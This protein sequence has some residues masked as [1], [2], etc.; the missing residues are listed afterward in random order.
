MQ[1]PRG[2]GEVHAARGDLLRVRHAVPQRAAD[3]A[4]GGVLYA[5]RGDPQEGRPRPRALLRPQR[6]LPPHRG[7]ESQA[8]RS[9]RRES[10]ARSCV[11]AQGA[12]SEALP[13]CRF[14]TW[15]Q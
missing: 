7:R 5:Q 1:V 11:C 10:L 3:E 14:R 15:R 12:D 6:R 13:L 8:H 4:Q 2:A 9:A